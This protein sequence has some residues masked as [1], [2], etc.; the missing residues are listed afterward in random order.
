LINLLVKKQSS[1][2]IPLAKATRLA[3]KIVALILFGIYTL[4]VVFYLISAYCLLALGIYGTSAMYKKEV[5][6]ML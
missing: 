1:L 6:I 5:I 2:K 4:R 3:R